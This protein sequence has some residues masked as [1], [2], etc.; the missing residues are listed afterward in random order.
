METLVVRVDPTHSWQDRWKTTA[1]NFPPGETSSDETTFVQG[2]DGLEQ[3]E[4]KPSP[5]IT[6]HLAKS[7]PKFD[8]TRIR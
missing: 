3:A 8:Q 4:S 7:L 5:Q 2:T 6:S 1:L